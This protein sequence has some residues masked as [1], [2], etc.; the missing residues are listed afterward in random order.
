MSIS[1]ELIVKE[2][3]MR[4]ENEYRAPYSSEFEFYLLVKNGEV[5]KIKEFSK[6]EFSEKTGF[7]K[8]CENPLQNIKYHFVVTAALIARYCIDGGMAHETAYNLSDLY[9]NRADKARSFKEI[10]E[11]HAEMSLDYTKRMR[12]ISKSRIFSKPIIIAVDY[13]YENIS[14]RITL[15]DLAE[16][17][18]LNESYLSRLFKKETGVTLTDFVNNRRI[19]LAKHLL[20]TTNLQIQTIAQHCGILDFHYFCRMFKKSVGQTPTQYREN[21]IFS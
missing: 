8:L 13:I 21:L 18:G 2:Y 5:E 3:I 19:R 20:K 15:T 14:K 4:E 7:G 16:V 12:R 6:K 11:L 10:S 1:E 17:T 9:I